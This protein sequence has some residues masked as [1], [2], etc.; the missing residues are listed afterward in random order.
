MHHVTCCG[1][2]RAWPR[3]R[4]GR[5]NLHEQSRPG[6]ASGDLVVHQGMI[7]MQISCK[8]ECKH[9]RCIPA[10]RASR[11]QSIAA[12]SASQLQLGECQCDSDGWS[13]QDCG[14]PY[15]SRCAHGECVAPHV[16]RCAEDWSGPGCDS[17]GK[18]TYGSKVALTVL[19]K[20]DELL[21]SSATLK[22]TA[23][24]HQAVVATCV[25]RNGPTGGETSGGEWWQVF[26]PSGTSAAFMHNQTIADGAHV[27][28]QHIDSGTWLRGDNLIR[29][30]VR[31]DLRE[32]SSGT[33][34]D[35]SE[36]WNVYVDRGKHCAANPAPTASES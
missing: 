36:D 12:G 9:G 1:L 30:K 32:V 28:L 8:P 24:L 7:K 17:R 21:F 13:G 33:N 23:G 31:H 29:S 27:R 35:G 15:C 34:V 11:A 4:A 19:R 16:C 26:G 22:T 6:D 14:V 18:I 25:T 10:A 2:T 3:T 20:K 5:R